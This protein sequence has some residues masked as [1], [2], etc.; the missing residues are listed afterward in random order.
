MKIA[1]NESNPEEFILVYTRPGG[2]FL[3]IHDHSLSKSR[4]LL[5]PTRMQEFTFF[6]GFESKVSST[7]VQLRLEEEK[8]HL[9][10]PSDRAESMNSGDLQGVDELTGEQ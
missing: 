3:N 9:V 7:F 8:D 6:P 4:V 1:L 10:I 5:L 2:K